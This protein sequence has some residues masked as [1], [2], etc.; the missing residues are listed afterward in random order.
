M[1]QI[2][3]ASASPSRYRL[4]ESVGIIPEVIVSGVNEE[5]PEFDLLNPNNRFLYSSSSLSVLAYSSVI[6]FSR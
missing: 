2:I 5:S 6:L 4:L 3:L 1:V